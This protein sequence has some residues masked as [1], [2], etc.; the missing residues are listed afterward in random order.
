MQDWVDSDIPQY[1]F[2]AH[3]MLLLHARVRLVDLEIK[4]P[5]AAHKDEIK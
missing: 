3:T 5:P 1:I 2:G 4:Q